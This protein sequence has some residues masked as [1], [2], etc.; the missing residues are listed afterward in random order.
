[1]A[2]LTLKPDSTGG[3]SKKKKSVND[4]HLFLFY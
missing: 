4:I 3:E 1:M 2:E